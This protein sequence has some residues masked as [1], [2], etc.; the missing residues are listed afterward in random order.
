[1]FYSGIFVLWSLFYFAGLT[2][3]VVYKDC[4]PFTSGRIEKQDQILP[5]LVANKLASY[6]GLCGLFLA[7]IYGGVLRYKFMTNI[8]NQ[9][10]II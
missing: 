7:G 2:A 9:F 5:F 10:L 8:Y 1:M 3:Y 4:D 6:P